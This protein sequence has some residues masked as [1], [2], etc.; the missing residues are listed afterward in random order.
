[1]HHKQQQL[2]LSTRVDDNSTLYELVDDLCKVVDQNEQLKDKIWDQVDTISSTLG[3]S[4]GKETDTGDD[5]NDLNQMPSAFKYKEQYETLQK[6]GLTDQPSS[7]K[8]KNLIYQSLKSLV[9]KPVTVNK[10]KEDQLEREVEQLKMLL[11]DRLDYNGQLLNTIDEY[12]NQLIEI[13]DTMARR[14]TDVNTEQLKVMEGFKEELIK[15]KEEMYGKY[16]DYTKIEEQGIMLYD[17][18]DKI[19]D[20]L[21]TIDLTSK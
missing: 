17:C 16:K 5:N 12:E 14:H 3:E 19:A 13:M 7:H 20:Y 6:L 9:R 11:G 15:L 4:R 2:S 21:K 8:S 1:M 18:V 10:K